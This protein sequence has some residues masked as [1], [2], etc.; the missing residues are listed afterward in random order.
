L[1]SI[2]VFNKLMFPQSYSPPRPP[3]FR[4]EVT[5]AQGQLSL[6]AIRLSQPI[7]S[8]LAAGTA[9][10]LT[11]LFI[12]FVALGSTTRKAR[13]TGITVPLGGSINVAASN[14]GVIVHSLAAEG[15]IVAAGQP[16]FEIS[17][18]RQSGHGEITELIAQQLHNRKQNLDVPSDM[19]PAS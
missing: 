4:P 3:L 10:G 15:Q 13:V 14:A 6:G 19:A 9:L 8:T 16:L 7:S 18:E 5:I 12:A 2:F 17:T 1:E 11:V